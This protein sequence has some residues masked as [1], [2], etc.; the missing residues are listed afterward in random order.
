MARRESKGSRVLTLSSHNN[1]VGAGA[2]RC[3]AGALVAARPPPSVGSSPGSPSPTPSSDDNRVG[4]GAVWSGAGALV[5]ARSASSVGSS[6][7][8]P[9]PTPSSDDNR[10]GAGVVWC[11]AGAL[12]AARPP[13]PVGSGSTSPT[14]GHKGPP[15]ASAPHPPLRASLFNKISLT[16]SHALIV[17]HCSTHFRRIERRLAS[18][19][20]GSK[21]CPRGS[22]TVSISPSRYWPVARK[23]ARLRP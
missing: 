9:S 16:I 15:P 2:A 10:V 1:R 14:G 17:R 23:K 4:A 20:G 22:G 13:S 8:S 21:V 6:P 5:A 12:V 3:G 7:G 19:Y 18:K 11:G